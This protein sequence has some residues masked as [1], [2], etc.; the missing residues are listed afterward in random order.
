VVQYQRLNG[1]RETATLDAET[2]RR[3]DAGPAP[4]YG[5]SGAATRTAGAR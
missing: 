1:L 5:G 4:S 2:L 3:L